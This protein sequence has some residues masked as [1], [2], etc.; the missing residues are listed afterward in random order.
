MEASIQPSVSSANYAAIGNVVPPPPKPPRQV[1][2]L[3]PSGESRP[4]RR[5]ENTARDPPVLQLIQRSAE[6]FGRIA[7]ANREPE[8]GAARSGA[9]EAG[10]SPGAYIDR[11]A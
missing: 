11:Y 2:P 4:D 8:A 7:A 6:L 1:E 9:A 5:D 3:R 10:P